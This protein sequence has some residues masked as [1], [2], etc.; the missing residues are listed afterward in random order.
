LHPVVVEHLRPLVTP[1]PVKPGEKRQA[2]TH[3]FVFRWAHDERTLWAEFGR[4]QGEAGIHLE[5]IDRHRHTP[6]C[7]VY[8]FH[9]LRRAFATVNAP[10]MKPEALQRLMRHKSYLTT[11]RYVNMVDQVKEAVETM[12]VPEALR[13]APAEA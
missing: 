10:R 13:K 8:G 1:P 5:C 4:I 11:L 9:D 2:P 6:A 3:P 7:H 12:P